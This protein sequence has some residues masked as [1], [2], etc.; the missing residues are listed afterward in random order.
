MRIHSNVGFCFGEKASQRTTNK[1]PHLNL[2]KKRKEK[3]KRENMLRDTT[4]HGKNQ[5]HDGV[6]ASVDKEYE[7]KS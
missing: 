2:P 7:R 6:H 3:P 5:A 1:L 4:V